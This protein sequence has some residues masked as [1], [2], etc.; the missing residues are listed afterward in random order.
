MPKKRFSYKNKTLNK[1]KKGLSKRKYN[2]KSKINRNKKKRRT[3]RKTKGGAGTQTNEGAQT[4]EELYSAP[5]VTEVKPININGIT[6]HVA[7]NNANDLYAVGDDI[8]EIFTDY[9][10][11]E[12]YYDTVEPASVPVH[13]PEPVELLKSL[14]K[15]PEVPASPNTITNITFCDTNIFGTHN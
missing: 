9:Y 1:N 5:P 14:N 8:T 2:K 12:P 4:N 10:D 6:V 13:V 7:L 3:I 11:A 15:L